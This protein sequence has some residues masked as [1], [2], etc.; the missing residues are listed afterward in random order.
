MLIIKRRIGE[1]VVIADE[2]YCTVLDVCGSSVRLG[3]DAPRALPINRLE[4]QNA[5]AHQ[6]DEVELDDQSILERLIRKFKCRG[7]GLP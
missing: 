7:L 6:R 4:V 1:L 5:L 3:F 2:V